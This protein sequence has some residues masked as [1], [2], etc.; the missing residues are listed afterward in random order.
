MTSQEVKVE[1]LR[2]LILDKQ[3]II[4]VTEGMNSSDVLGVT[5][6]LY[7][8][9][10]EVKVDK[11]DLLGEIK[12]IKCVLNGVMQQPFRNRNKV[13]KHDKYIGHYYDI[14]GFVPNRFYFAVPH[15]LTDIAV[16]GVEN[17]PYGVVT[18]GD[19]YTGYNNQVKMW[20]YCVQREAQMLSKDKLSIKNL[21]KMARKSCTEAYFLRS[22]L[23]DIGR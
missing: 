10:Y 20:G 16:A 19:Y 2:T 23:L 13:Y 17:T 12:D 8:A 9:E 4:A 1:L 11:N 14:K 15:E 21:I 5:K 22:K 18:V 3:Y 6:A 7:T